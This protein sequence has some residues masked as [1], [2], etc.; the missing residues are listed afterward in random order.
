MYAKAHYQWIPS[1]SFAFV[2]SSP[3]YSKY[4]TEKEI[5]KFG[6][7]F[8]KLLECLSRRNENVFLS[9]QFATVI[10]MITQLQEGKLGSLIVLTH[11]FSL[12]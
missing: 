8:P 3:I 4:V 2:T 12:T 5:L 9:S 10:I 7:S 6:E 11:S 1:V